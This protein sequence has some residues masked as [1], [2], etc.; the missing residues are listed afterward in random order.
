[1]TG[2]LEIAMAGRRSACRK[3]SLRCLLRHCSTPMSL[4]IRDLGI[5]CS[6]RGVLRLYNVSSI[7][8]TTRSTHTPDNAVLTQKASGHGF[9]LMMN[10]V[11]RGPKN[12][13]AMSGPDQ[14]LIFRLVRCQ[15]DLYTTNH[16]PS[17]HVRM[18]VEEKHI[19]DQH[20]AVL[21]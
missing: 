20:Q 11:M 10:A 19:L 7:R 12:G 16:M 6:S 14:M 21:V 17:K 5:G 1:M 4:R 15:R 18:L 13:D 2:I 8:Q 3:V 9:L